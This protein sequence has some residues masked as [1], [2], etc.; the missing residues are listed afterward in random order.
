MYYKA[1]YD[2]WSLSTTL[3]GQT[4]VGITMLNGCGKINCN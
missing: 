4:H 1:I 3:Q 2:S